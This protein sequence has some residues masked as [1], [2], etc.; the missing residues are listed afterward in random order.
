MHEENEWVS[1]FN[2]YICGD[3]WR[4]IWELNIDMILA[5]RRIGDNYEAK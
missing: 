4:G 1:D 2:G 5:F 3:D